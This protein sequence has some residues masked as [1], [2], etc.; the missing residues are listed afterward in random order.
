MAEPTASTDSV[1]TTEAKEP[2]WLGRLVA[3]EGGGRPATAAFLV[4]FAGAGA[5]VGSLTLEWMS[6][7]I[8]ESGLEETRRD[9]DT[10]GV[11]LIT[12]AALGQVYTLAGIALLGVVGA[13][14]T[15]PQAALRLRM[16]MTGAGVGLLGLVVAAHLSLGER[17]LEQVVGPAFPILGP[18]VSGY[19]VALE[20]GI[21]CA[22]AA[23]VLPVLAVWMVS[24]RAARGQV[25]PHPGVV[26]GPQSAPATSPAATPAAPPP[27]RPDSGAAR[28]RAEV[29]EPTPPPPPLGGGVTIG[30]LTVSPSEPIDLSV[31]PEAWPR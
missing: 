26:A 6:L 12:G 15:R 16:G 22:Y 3:P 28:Q 31:T 11:S 27:D 8:P 20:A 24:R 19:T 10:Y 7:A 5:F 29:S 4:A 2:G 30:E 13:V 23:V 14:I 1:W 21:F 18:Q 9:V 17:A 25:E